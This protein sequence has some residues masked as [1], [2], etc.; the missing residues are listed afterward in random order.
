MLG[1]QSDLITTNIIG[2]DQ[3][4]GGGVPEGS[5]ILVVGAPGTGKT[6]FLQQ[7]CFGWVKSRH[8]RPTNEPKNSEKKASVLEES[9][10]A[11][12]LYFSTLSEPHIKL[13]RH[14]SQ[15]DFFDAAMLPEQINFLSLS[16][17]MDSGLKAVGDLILNTVRQQKAE[18]VTLDGL[19]AL[20]DVAES[21]AAIRMFLYRLSAQLG[22]LG[23]TSFISIERSLELG[24][25]ED[26]LTVAD[27]ILNMTRQTF[28]MQR[29][30]RAEVIKL[31]GMK[32]LSGKHAYDITQ[33]GLRFY[34]RLESL[35]VK[36][37]VFPGAGKIEQRLN[38][39]LPEL[40]KM[41]GGGIPNSSST[42]VTGSPG[43][44]KTILSLHYLMAGVAKGEKGLYL[45]FYESEEQ[46]VA[47]AA[48]FN[49]DLRQALKDQALQIITL[50]PV[51]LEADKVVTDLRKLIEADGIKRLVID[52]LIQLELVC[53]REERAHDFIAALLNY[54]K[55]QEITTFYTYEIGKIMGIDLDLSNSGFA[56]L[57]ENLLLL[58]QVEYQ[59]KLFSIISVLK[60]RDSSYDRTIRQFTIMDEDGFKVLEP[61]ESAAGV[62]SGVAKNLADGN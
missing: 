10:T 41:L 37:L 57:A 50:N 45:G 14:I 59:T 34:P 17:A 43:T 4:S 56:P 8:N 36:E 30:W 31:R 44:G 42:V 2:F 16:T 55:G 23:V 26:L 5:L 18:L 29:I 38:F 52:G 24:N 19:V 20:E 1:N 49:L 60:M 13:I 46:L 27:G 40:E 61:L 28:G 21:K 3:L 12:A 9:P 35:A 51:E 15:F 22:A 32:H 62:L 58:K 54:L 7:L 39:G 47:K 25:S 33:A 48:R 6:V 53:Q 11:K